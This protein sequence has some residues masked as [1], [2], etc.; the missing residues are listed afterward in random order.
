MADGA[1]GQAVDGLPFPLIHLRITRN[2]R[3]ADYVSLEAGDCYG[4]KINI[5]PRSFGRILLTLSYTGPDQRGIGSKSR[6]ICSVAVNV[7]TNGSVKL[8]S[9]MLI[10]TNAVSERVYAASALGHLCDA[11]AVP[12]L[13]QAV[14][15]DADP[16]VRAVSI[17]ALQKTL[18]LPVDSLPDINAAINAATDPSAMFEAQAAVINS[19]LKDR[20]NIVL[21]VVEGRLKVVPK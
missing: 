3:E 8:L 9:N 10:K 1:R 13:T 19:W 17:V 7:E 20:T 5:S 16:W 21:R 15:S 11:S 14:R 2:I 4:R 18:R 12:V 6:L